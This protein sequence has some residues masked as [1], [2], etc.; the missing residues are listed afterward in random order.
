MKNRTMAR[1]LERARVQAREDA[2]IECSC[3]SA[4]CGGRPR[5]NYGLY[6]C[7][8]QSSSCRASLQRTT[9]PTGLAM[10]SWVTCLACGRLHFVNP[11]T[12]GAGASRYG[13]GRA[14]WNPHWSR[15]DF[16]LFQAHRGGHGCG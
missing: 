10:S 8:T 5:L 13:I 9:S 2:A 11:K 15:S 14:L 16:D 1:K 7:P 3:L 4:N 12:G 6:R